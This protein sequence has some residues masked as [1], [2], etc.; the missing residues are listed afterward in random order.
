MSSGG[1]RQC[2]RSVT[3]YLILIVAISALGPLQFGLHLV[4]VQVTPT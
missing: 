2:V 4:S 3:P 1:L